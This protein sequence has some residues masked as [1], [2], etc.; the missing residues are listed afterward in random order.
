MEIN[1]EIKQCSCCIKKEFIPG[2]VTLKCQECWEEEKNQE[3]FVLGISWQQKRFPDPTN[4]NL[5]E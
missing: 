1:Y 3:Y 4:R 5:I 2:I